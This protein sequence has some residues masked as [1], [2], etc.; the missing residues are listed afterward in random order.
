M[1]ISQP[2][3]KEAGGS[4]DSGEALLTLFFCKSALKYLPPAELSQMPVY[5]GQR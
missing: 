2:S 1:G 3:L 5:I 4:D